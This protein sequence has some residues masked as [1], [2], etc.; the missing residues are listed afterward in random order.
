MLKKKKIV[1]KTNSERE[2]RVTQEKNKFYY[3]DIYGII[4]TAQNNYFDFLLLDFGS[5]L[6]SE[7]LKL[8]G[9]LSTVKH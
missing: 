6:H 5:P 2:S 8:S 4:L 1:S 3:L 7:E 9:N